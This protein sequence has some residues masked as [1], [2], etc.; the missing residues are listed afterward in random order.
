MLLLPFLLAL[1]SILLELLTQ[2]SM[3]RRL[4]RQQAWL[5]LPRQHRQLHLLPGQLL[6]W[7]AQPTLPAQPRI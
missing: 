1:M 4:Q 6:Q 5:W 3:K 2:G 7:L